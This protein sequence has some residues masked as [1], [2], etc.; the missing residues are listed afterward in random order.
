MATI[1]SM[2]KG[3]FFAKMQCK[4]T[5][6]VK[7]HIAPLSADLKKLTNTVEGHTGEIAELNRKYDEVKKLT[8]AGI[9]SGASSSGT[10]TAP[11]VNGMASNAFVP[12]FIEI[13]NFC[14]FKE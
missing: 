11:T 13:L 3:S 2:D 1:G 10:S 7:E 4:I 9:Q 14:E 12:T 6:T 8:E 5:Q